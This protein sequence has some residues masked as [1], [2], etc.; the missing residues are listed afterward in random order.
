MTLNPK[1]SRRRTRIVEQLDHM[2]ASGRV[3]EDE[4]VRMRA[5]SS[6]TEF[7]AVV[8]E[9]RARHAAPRLAAAVEAGEMTQS[10]ADGALARLR[11]GEHSGSLRA[12]LHGLLAERS[13]H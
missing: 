8:A 9:V 12:R 10:E 1:D 11:A 7:D 3:T 5:A 4:A 13:R 2:V 6:A